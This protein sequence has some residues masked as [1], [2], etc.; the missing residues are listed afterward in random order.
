MKILWLDINSSYSHSSVALPA[1]HAQ[2]MDRTDWEWSVV[3][4]T[5]NDNP[6][7]L[8]AVVAQQKPDVIAA[9]FWLFTHQ[10]QIEVLSRVNALLDSAKV[11]CGGPEFLGCNEAFLR[12]HPFVTAI[13]K[14]EGEVALPQLLNNFEH[15]SAWDSIAGLCWIGDDGKYR[16]NGIAR[17]ADFASLRYPEESP[18]FLW[19]K[20]FVQLETTR[21]CFN[22]CAFCVSGGEKPVRYQT[23][24][25]VSRR[26]ENIYEHGI[27]DVNGFR[28]GI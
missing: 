14:G 12:K 23:L 22:T 5:I 3:R 11:I 8:A 10:M 7:V 17:V 18:F 6:G 19:D 16:D 2:V 24:E 9:T 27:K 20:P 13:I 21:G 1:I 25:Q 26:L 28:R 4:G 15:P